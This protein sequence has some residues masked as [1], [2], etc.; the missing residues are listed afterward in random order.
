MESE[1]RRWMGYRYSIT[2]AVLAVMTAATAAATMVVQ[3]PTPLTRGYINVGD[4][5]VMISALTFGALVGGIAG[6]VG[7]ALADLLSGY[8]HWAPWT[9]VIKGVEGTVAGYI[10]GKKLWRDVL[11]AIVGGA[12]MFTGY[13]LVEWWLYGFGPALVEL[14]GN[15]FQATVGLVVG[16]P[17][18]RALRKSLGFLKGTI[19]LKE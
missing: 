19:P 14:P 1:S 13:F 12:C 11:A 2:V 4:S 15:M 7:S 10:S 3:V 9:L 6:G 16:V 17:V 5:L 8:P 18:S